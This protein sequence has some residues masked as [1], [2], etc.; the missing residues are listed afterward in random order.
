M[1]SAQFTSW[2][3]TEKSAIIVF[4]SCAMSN[5]W[6]QVAKEKGHNARI[7]SAKLASQIKSKQC[8]AVAFALL[9][10]ETDYKAEPLVG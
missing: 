1:S 2:L 7:L 6:K 5:Y 4:E 10:Q 8:V 3:A 9:T